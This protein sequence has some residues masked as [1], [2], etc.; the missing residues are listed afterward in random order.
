VH[1]LRATRPADAL[2]T[3]IGVPVL[4]EVWNLVVDGGTTVI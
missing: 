3:Q 2:S 4:E 1:S